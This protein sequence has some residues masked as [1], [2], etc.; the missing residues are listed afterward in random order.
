[1]KICELVPS[2]KA[3]GRWL[4]S[5]EDGSKLRLTDREVADFALHSGLDLSPQTR[6][7]LRDAA[8]ESGAR[9]RAV[10]LLSARPLSRRE[11]ERR[12]VEKGETPQHAAAAADYMEHLGYLDDRAYALTLARHYSDKGCGPRKVRE[13]LYRRGVPREYWDEALEGLESPE[14]A[15]DAFVAAKLRRVAEPGPQDFKRV[16]DALARRGYAW[17]DISAA[18]RRYADT[19]K[20]GSDFS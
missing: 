5:F 14:E 2:P 4:A 16:S 19:L 17:S 6:A 9:R 7:R 3:K 8:G 15:L 10:N 11:L 1:M 12:L 18:V 13:E 20:D